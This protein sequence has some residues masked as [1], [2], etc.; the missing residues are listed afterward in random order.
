MYIDITSKYTIVEDGIVYDHRYINITH[1]YIYIVCHA[2]N[3]SI[4]YYVI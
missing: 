4:M 1:I 3:V 2:R